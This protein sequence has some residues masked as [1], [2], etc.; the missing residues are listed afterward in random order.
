MAKPLY[1]SNLDGVGDHGTEC[2]LA[3]CRLLW[4]GPYKGAGDD[5]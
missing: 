5:H 4:W 3:S 2:A 1:A